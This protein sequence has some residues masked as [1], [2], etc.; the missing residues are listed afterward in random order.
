M[1]QATTQSMLSQQLSTTYTAPKGY[2][3]ELLLTEHRLKQSQIKS[4][5]ITILTGAGGR[6]LI[7]ETLRQRGAKVHIVSTYKRRCPVYTN[8]QDQIKPWLISD[9]KIT[10]ITSN[11]CLENL[12]SMLPVD[13][14]ELVKNNLMIVPSQRVAKFAE[15]LGCK[16]IKIA[17]SASD[18]DM[19]AVI[20]Q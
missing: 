11:N 17:N 10:L 19:L 4:K 14:A 20:S 5:D 6:S 9:K 7:Q 3:S 2:T 18:E 15:F 8:I 16:K 12:L 13:E 1:G